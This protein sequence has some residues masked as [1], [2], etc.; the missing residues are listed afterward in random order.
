METRRSR[1]GHQDSDRPGN[2]YHGNGYRYGVFGAAKYPP[3]GANGHVAFDEF[4]GG[5]EPNSTEQGAQNSG[6]KTKTA[7][8]ASTN[9]S[10]QFWENYIGAQMNDRK[11]RHELDSKFTE[12]RNKIMKQKAKKLEKRAT[13]CGFCPMGAPRHT[14]IRYCV[15]CRKHMCGRC[16]DAHAM[17]SLCKHH[18]TINIS[19][20]EYNSALL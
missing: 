20:G 9:K 3:N 8:Q 7:N 2:S 15:H 17:D 19:K 16:A 13:R 18:G 12:Q 6:R 14:L 5:L 10:L 1:D 4:N 11:V